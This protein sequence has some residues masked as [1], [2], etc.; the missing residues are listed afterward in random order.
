MPSAKKTAPIAKKATAPAKAASKMTVTLKHLA[1]AL[2]DSHN[3]AKR[4]AEAVLRTWFTNEE[5]AAGSGH[6]RSGRVARD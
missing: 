3:I 1:A 6:S 5:E 4:Q 2:A